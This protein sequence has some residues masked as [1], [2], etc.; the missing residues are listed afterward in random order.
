[1]A[2][3]GE[4]ISLAIHK[5]LDFYG[6]LNLAATIE[7]LS[8]SALVGLQLGKLG[9]PETKDIGFDGADAGYVPDLEVQAIR[10]GG[11]VDNALSGKICGHFS[12]KGKRPSSRLGAFSQGSIGTPC[13]AVKQKTRQ[14]AVSD[15]IRVTG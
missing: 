15:S 14:I 5:A 12:P 2:G 7:T 13:A 8:G 4:G 1:M 11:R 9:L 6:D 10:D 3:A